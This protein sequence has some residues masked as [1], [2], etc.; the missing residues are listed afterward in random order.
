MQNQDTISIYYS[1]LKMLFDEV[2]NYEF[3]SYYIC[4][5]LRT[6][7][8]YQKRDWLIKLFYGLTKSHKVI[9]K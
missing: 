5:G 8:Q 6:I 3:V 4:G 2:F 1:K 9:K 7:I